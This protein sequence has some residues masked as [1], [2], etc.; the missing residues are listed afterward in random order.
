MVNGYIFVVFS[1]RIWPWCGTVMAEEGNQRE[2][3][4]KIKLRRLS[5]RGYREIT[6]EGLTSIRNLSLDLLDVTY[7]GV[8]KEGIEKFLTLNPNCRVLHPNYCV[9]KPRI[10]C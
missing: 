8:T 7:T 9:C 10:P 6:D 1:F 3:K 2:N 4:E 5:L